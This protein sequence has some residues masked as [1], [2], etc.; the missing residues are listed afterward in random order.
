VDI[1]LGFNHLSF[2]ELVARMRREPDE[3]EV[4]ADPELAATYYMDVG[5]ALGDLGSPGVSWLLGEAS[6]VEGDERR[7]R[8]VL[9]GLARREMPRELAHAARAVFRQH[10]S[11]TRP[12]IMMVA[13]D[14]LGMLQD[15]EA[16]NA[17]LALRGNPSEWVRGAVLTY[18]Q[19][20]APARAVPMA[21]DALADAHFIVRE[22]AID[23]LDEL[24][25]AGQY[26]DRIRPLLDDEHPHVRSAAEWSI[27]AAEES[28]GTE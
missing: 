10:L 7:L 22:T 19:S 27:E 12:L 24:G 26:L 13:V 9:A 23:T 28:D 6:R 17:V 8:G 20:C 5:F 16:M 11:D 2:E 4:A 25:V 21:L 18:M 3:S 1:N 14:G 15:V